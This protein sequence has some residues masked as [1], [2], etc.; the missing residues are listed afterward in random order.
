MNRRTPTRQKKKWKLRLRP[1][2]L[3]SFVAS[4]NWAFVRCRRTIVIH[5]VLIVRDGIRS[6]SIRDA[7][8]KFIASNDRFRC[9][10]FLLRLRRRRDADINR[11]GHMQDAS[12]P[13]DVKNIRMTWHFSPHRCVQHGA[14]QYSRVPL[15]HLNAFQEHDRR[16]HE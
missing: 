4:V 13:I 3:I 8:S 7:P 1:R 11:C 16:P 10:E 15:Q 6:G 5:S 14:S 9:P 2:Q 12:E